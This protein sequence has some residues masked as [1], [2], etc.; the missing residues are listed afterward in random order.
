MSDKLKQ[1]FLNLITEVEQTEELNDILDLLLTLKEYQ[2]IAN[3][4]E[5]FKKLD[6]GETQRDISDELEVSIATVTRGSREMQN[7]PDKTQKLLDLI[8]EIET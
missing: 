6:E 7:K 3:R 8:E 4:V 5:I 2:E 1:Q